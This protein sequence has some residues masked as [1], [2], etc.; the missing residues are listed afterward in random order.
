MQ[1]DIDQLIEGSNVNNGSCDLSNGIKE[2]LN[3]INC[4]FEENAKILDLIGTLEQNLFTDVDIEDRLIIALTF[5]QKWQIENPTVYKLIKYQ[6]ISSLKYLDSFSKIVEF[7]QLSKV[8]ALINL[9]NDNNCYLFESLQNNT[10]NFYEMNAAINA[11]I[12]ESLIEICSN[13]SI[14]FPQKSVLIYETFS[15]FF[16]INPEWK[17]LFLQFQIENF[18]TFQQFFE[19]TQTFYQISK[20]D[21]I[22]E[23][24][25]SAF[26]NAFKHQLDNFQFDTTSM[27]K[28]RFEL[29]YESIQQKFHTVSS[30]KD[31]ILIV[32]K[33]FQKFLQ[34]YSDI[35]YVKYLYEIQ[36]NDFGS[37]MD[38]IFCVSRLAGYPSISL[39]TDK[40]SVNPKWTC[41][42]SC[43][44]I[45]TESLSVTEEETFALSM[46]DNF[47]QQI[48]TTIP[49]FEIK[50]ENDGMQIT[51]DDTNVI[52][53]SDSLS[54]PV[55]L[56]NG[57]ESNVSVVK[58]DFIFQTSQAT[59]YTN[60]EIF[61]IIQTQEDIHKNEF[62]NGDKASQ[63]LS[64]QPEEISSATTTSFKIISSNFNSE[65]DA[66]TPTVV[67]ILEK[68]NPTILPTLST[69]NF[70]KVSLGLTTTLSTNK[71][72]K[73]SVE[74]QVPL[75][76]TI[77]P[78][79]IQKGDE[80]KITEKE[81]NQITITDNFETL[82]TIAIS[83]VPFVNEEA[84]TKV[85]NSKNNETFSEAT[86][87]LPTKTLPNTE[88]LSTRTTT[89]PSIHETIVPFGNMAPIS[90]TTSKSHP[91]TKNVFKPQISNF[92]KKHLAKFINK[93]KNQIK[94][95]EEESESESKETKQ[96]KKLFSSKSL[97]KKDSKEE[98]SKIL[99]A[100][101]KR[102]L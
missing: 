89:L 38:V 82:T 39:I 87:F 19:I 81:L 100:K 96:A 75:S 59:I 34:F 72:D 42:C 91:S 7:R 79:T 50:N 29:L 97:K 17:L 6:N 58:Q 37:F 61:T 25:N 70:D 13:L 86:T 76:N 40:P 73:V 28:Q 36:I 30:E 101:F 66:V 54:T 9:D 15:H 8:E 48:S 78:T 102:H 14:S 23:G 51:N 57:D 92:D 77:P 94:S 20:I 22:F 55:T 56:E 33:E 21:S 80:E 93:N 49:T 90:T 11:L 27:I 3:V 16:V 71:F 35:E 67:D 95:S 46:N 41:S 53:K 10:E 1:E 62:S 99:K 31:R 65:N 44:D 98:I 12:N 84:T 68:N 83:R 43:S 85:S 24:S 2:I 5:I 26:M 18:G 69:D 47:D 63:F 88:S 45:V 74:S 60:D 32:V 52:L 64:I 4:T